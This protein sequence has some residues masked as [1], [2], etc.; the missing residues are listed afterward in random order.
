MQQRIL[1][2]QAATLAD[3]AV[4]VRRLVVLAEE[5]PD[6]HA[7][8]APLSARQLIASALAVVE[9]SADGTRGQPG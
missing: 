6:P 3:A 5:R 1:R 2:A 9:R 7:L 4:Q 8:L